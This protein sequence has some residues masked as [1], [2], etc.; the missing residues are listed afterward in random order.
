MRFTVAIAALLVLVSGVS[1]KH[2]M[3]KGHDREVLDHINEHRKAHGKKPVE[4]ND[5]LHEISE[6]HS[7]YMA[8]Q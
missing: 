6:Y 2:T 3:P 5:H 1:C 4:W 8:D 7:H